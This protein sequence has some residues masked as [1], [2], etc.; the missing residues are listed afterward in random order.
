MSTLP[1]FYSLT[2]CDTTSCFY[3]RGKTSILNKVM[4]NPACIKLIQSLGND[5]VLSDRYTKDAMKFIQTIVYSGRDNESYVE[6]RVRLYKQ[7][8]KKLSISLPPDPSSCMQAAKRAHQK[9]FLWNRC[10]QKI[11]ENID[12]KENGWNINC[13]GQVI[14]IWYTCSQLPESQLTVEVSGR[15]FYYSYM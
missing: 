14:P 9:A 7:Q 5:V 2:G 3:N 10:L 12:L 4:K 6:T 15:K 11:I 1:Q 13:D 8:V